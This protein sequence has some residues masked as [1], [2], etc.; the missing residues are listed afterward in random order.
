MVVVCDI[1]NY[2]SMAL[3]DAGF[4]TFDTYFYDILL[5]H[6][7]SEND[8]SFRFGTNNTHTFQVTI[9]R[10]DTN[11]AAIDALVSNY[12]SGELRGLALWAF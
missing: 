2:S 5:G 3:M 10:D 12:T 7:K 11:T 8:I 4:L 9:N 6:A 1:P